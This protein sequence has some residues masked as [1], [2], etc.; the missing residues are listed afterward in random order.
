M[1]PIIPRIKGVIARGHRFLI[2]QVLVRGADDPE[3]D[4]QVARAAEFPV[5]DLERDGHFIVLVQDLVEAFALVG[6]E[7]DV[8]REGGGGEKAQEGGGKGLESHFGRWRRWRA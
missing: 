7:L 5:A 6:A 1:F 2:D 8:V 4:F 3:I